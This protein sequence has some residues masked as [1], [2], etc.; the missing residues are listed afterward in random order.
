MRGEHDR[1]GGRGGAP[2][3]VATP[4]SP[5]VG[6]VGSSES[7]TR[8]RGTARLVWKPEHYQRMFDLYPSHYNCAEFCQ[9]TISEMN[10]EMDTRR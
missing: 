6:W 5:L 7:P 4:K 3:G 8:Q 2:R 9:G 1:E 10:G